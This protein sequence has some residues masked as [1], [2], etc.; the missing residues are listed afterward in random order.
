M[1]LEWYIVRCR[2]EKILEKVSLVLLL[3]EICIQVTVAI[4]YSKRLSNVT[5]S[6]LVFHAVIWYTFFLFYI[7]RNWW[8]IGEFEVFHLTSKGVNSF[9]S[10]H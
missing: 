2:L 3:R 8:N 1:M 9:S 10:Y 7:V 4:R 6:P 5:G